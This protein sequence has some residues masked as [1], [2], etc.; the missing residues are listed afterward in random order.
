[1]TVNKANEMFGEIFTYLKNANCSLSSFQVAALERAVRWAYREVHGNRQFGNM[2]CQKC[3]TSLITL[4]GTVT[5]TWPRANASFNFNV[6]MTHIRQLEEWITGK[7]A[8]FDEFDKQ[9]Q[10]KLA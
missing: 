6:C 7:V 5:T 1:M 2:Y 9:N 8:R 4:V 10:A 3:G